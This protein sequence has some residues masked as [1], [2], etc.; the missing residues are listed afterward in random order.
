MSETK[1][2]TLLCAANTQ[3]TMP[4]T[5]MLTSVVSNLRSGRPLHVHVITSDIAEPAQIEIERSIKSVKTGYSE[6][7][8]NWY[9]IDIAGFAR[10]F[11]KGHL[12][13]IS[14]DTYSRLLAPEVL[15]ASV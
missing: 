6:L 8:F 14:P 13:Y 5:V 15:P 7:T 2:I 12:D 1:P 10:F 11:S 3:Y 4:L 9:T